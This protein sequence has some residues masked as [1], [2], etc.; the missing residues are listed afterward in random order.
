MGWGLFHPEFRPDLNAINPSI[1]EELAK[2][3]FKQTRRRKR[4]TT[5][6][7]RVRGSDIARSWT[8]EQTIVPIDGLITEKRTRRRGKGVTEEYS[9]FYVGPFPLIRFYRIRPPLVG[10]LLP[11]QFWSSRRMSH[12]IR[13]TKST[14]SRTPKAARCAQESRMKRTTLVANSKKPRVVGCSAMSPISSMPPPSTPA[15]LE[16]L[17]A[18]IAARSWK[19]MDVGSASITRKH[20]PWAVVPIR[21]GISITEDG[22][23]LLKARGLFASMA[24][25]RYSSGVRSWFPSKQ[26][27]S[28]QAS[29][30]LALVRAEALKRPAQPAL[31][32]EQWHVAGIRTRQGRRPSSGRADRDGARASCRAPSATRGRS[33][34]S[35]AHRGGDCS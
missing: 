22:Q 9:G 28:E 33:P 30:A 10:D 25:T 7:H 19:P 13:R 21:I 2:T 18:L 31:G 12:F 16:P 5:R 3:G 6:R 11:Y 32:R 27:A 26:A 29:S 15:Y 24:L 17:R 23:S 4:C 14:H 8:A 34:D 20:S 1:R 35:E